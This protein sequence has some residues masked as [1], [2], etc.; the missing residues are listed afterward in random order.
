MSECTEPSE[1]RYE[2]LMKFSS[3]YALHMTNSLSPPKEKT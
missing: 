1:F 3:R 2:Y